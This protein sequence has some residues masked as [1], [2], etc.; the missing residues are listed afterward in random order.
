[1]KAASVE[2]V[3]VGD[4]RRAVK[5]LLSDLEIREYQTELH[6]GS[7]STAHR[8]LGE[9]MVVLERVDKLLEEC[10]VPKPPKDES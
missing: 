2:I 1:M 7:G 9:Q 8:D 4:I 5:L 3:N 6:G 10:G